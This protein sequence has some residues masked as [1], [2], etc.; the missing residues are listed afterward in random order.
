[1]E[2]ENK[3]GNTRQGISMEEIPTEAL[4]LRVPRATR[5][6]HTEEEKQRRTGAQLA[7]VM[8]GPGALRDCLAVRGRRRG[9]EVRVEG[10]C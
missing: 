3:T 2:R 6:V 1:M 4:S 7:L 9:W 8:Q 10:R 5:R